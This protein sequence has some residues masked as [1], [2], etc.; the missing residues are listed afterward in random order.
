MT[1]LAEVITQILSSHP[2]TPE[3]RENTVLASRIALLLSTRDSPADIPQG[4]LSHM[5]ILGAYVSSLQERDLAESVIA[6][7]RIMIQDIAFMEDVEPMD[8]AAAYLHLYIVS[9]HGDMVRYFEHYRQQKDEQKT[10]AMFDAINDLL[11][12]GILLLARFPGS[13]PYRDELRKSLNF[14]PTSAMW[15]MEPQ[16]ITLQ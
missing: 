12:L 11:G 15:M 1:L 16:T 4:F 14:P 13:E 10:R 3:E 9:L 8:Q 6:T 5:R 2:E 7:L